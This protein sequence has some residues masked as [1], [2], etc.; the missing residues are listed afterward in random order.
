[1]L[2]GGMAQG[3]GYPRCCQEQLSSGD[4]SSQAGRHAFVA[5]G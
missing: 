2:A 3:S 4:E 5:G 1:E